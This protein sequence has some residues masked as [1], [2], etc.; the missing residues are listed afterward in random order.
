LITI[1]PNKRSTIEE[2][3]KIPITTDENRSD[4]WKGIQH[5]VLADTFLERSR[6]ADLIP[7]ETQWYVKNKGDLLYGCVD[8]KPTEVL[9][10]LDV[11]EKELGWTKECSFSVALRHSNDGR[12]TLG[13]LVG[14][15][16]IK[17]GSCFMTHEIALNKKHTRNSVL[18]DMIDDG[19]AE[20]VHLS[21]EIVSKMERYKTFIVS[22]YEAAYMIMMLVSYG[23]FK[24]EIGASIWEVWNRKHECLPDK[25][26]WRLYHCITEVTKTLP[27]NRQFVVLKDLLSAFR[28]ILEIR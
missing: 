25:N 2:L 22:D 26:A 21:P 6:D 23:E 9:H 24:P 14:L 5:G 1:H 16:L 15:R 8:F 27:P 19:I 4:N 7:T 12:Y 28:N 3:R 13:Y 20:F 10:R 11:P 18:E 17:T